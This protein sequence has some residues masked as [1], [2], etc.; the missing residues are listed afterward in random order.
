MCLWEIG[1][2]LPGLCFF[3]SETHL[4]YRRGRGGSGGCFSAAAGQLH[5]SI[6]L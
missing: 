4:S 1:Q 3:S 5:H 2:V 6:T